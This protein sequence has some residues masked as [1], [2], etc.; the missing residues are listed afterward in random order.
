MNGLINYVSCGMLWLGLLVRAPDLLRHRRDPYLRAICAVLGLA[1]LCFALGAPPTVGAVNR[2]S[3]VPNLAA[4]V[5]YAAITAYCAASQVLIVHWRGGPRVHR[6]ARCWILAYAGVVLGIAVTFTLADAPEE[7]RTDLDTYYATT[8]WIAQMIVLYL[9]AHLVAVTVTTVSSLT[10]ARRVRGRLRVG[11]TLFGAGSLCGAGYSVAKLVAVGA[12]WTGRDWPALGT[13]V[14]PAAAGLGAVMTVTGV[15]VPLVGPRVTDWRTARRTYA[16]L[17]PLER[18][19]DGLLTRRSLRLPRPR[20]ASPA[21]R[22][23]WRQTSIHN[24]LSHLDAYFDRHLYDRTRAAVLGTTGDPEWAEAAAWA[25]VITAAVRDEAD[26]RP[27]TPPPDGA[28]RLLDRV[29]GPAGLARIAD[30]L[31]AV[32]PPLPTAPVAG[33]T[34]PAGTA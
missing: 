5:T 25:A 29:P 12:R 13:A 34:T 30:A 1:G 18:V 3:G 32:A 6:T 19:L 2:L 21:T 31:S 14:S 20:C 33:G 24:A 15:L 10:W 26:A 8:P 11:L 17:A 23:M 27:G 9:L 7:R 22:L 28:G 16:R 4:P